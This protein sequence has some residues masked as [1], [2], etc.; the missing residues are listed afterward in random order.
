MII[1]LRPVEDGDRSFL[2]DVYASTRED[3]LK[4]VDWTPEQKRAFCE[5]QFR[6]QDTYYRNTYTNVTY[7]VVLVDGEPGGRLYV[8]RQ[9]DHILVLDVALLPGF[10]GRGIGTRLLADVQAEAVASAKPLRIHVERFNPA[11]RLYARLGFGLIADEGVY[12]H[13][14]WRPPEVAGEATR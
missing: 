11:L 7:D 10:R 4:L 9:P 14:E 6:A 3:E 5:M 2:M 8:C 13:L 12:L 1:S